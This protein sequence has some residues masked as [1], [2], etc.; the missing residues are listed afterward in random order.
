MRL[1][2]ADNVKEL[3]SDEIDKH[4]NAWDNTITV[5]EMITIAQDTID[6]APTIAVNCKDCD[7]YEAGYSAGLCDSR[8]NDMAKEE[9]FD[10][11]SNKTFEIRYKYTKDHVIP[12][13]W[14]ELDIG[15]VFYNIHLNKNIYIKTSSKAYFSI[16]DRT[17]H[18]RSKLLSEGSN[19]YKNYMQVNCE[20]RVY[21]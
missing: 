10:V 8:G 6:N 1:I 17:Y 5:A 16:T 15:S 21:D 20:V 12:L 14:D 2:D 11:F 18:T 7:G 13:S 19:K 3:I 9:I 4:F